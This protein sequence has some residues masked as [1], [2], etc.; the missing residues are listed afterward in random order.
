MTENIV[1]CVTYIIY[2]LLYHIHAERENQ[3]QI[4]ILEGQILSS[5]QN[6]MKDYFSNHINKTHRNLKE[7]T[8]TA[9]I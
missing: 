8:K 6:Q 5:L 1:F 4:T 3:F 2:S 9:E 7:V